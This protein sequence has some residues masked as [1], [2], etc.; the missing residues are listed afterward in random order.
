MKKR[1]IPSVLVA[2]VA[3][4]ALFAEGLSAPGYVAA[5]TPVFAAPE[6]GGRPIG[7]LLPA[8]PLIPLGPAE[9]GWQRVAVAGWTQSGAERALQAAPGLRVTRAALSKAGL[10][11]LDFGAPQTDPDTGLVW[12][13]TTLT[14]WVDAGAESVPDLQSLW[15]RAN[16][17]FSTRCTA[18]HVRRVPAR[19]T[20]NQWTSHLKVMGPRTGL[21]KDD[22]ALIRVF[23]QYHSADAT[24]LAAALEQ[25]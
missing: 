15:T 19:Y 13:R 14:G 16:T 4:T 2:C 10:E 24:A 8:A 18:C 25:D 22:Q 23:L 1:F 3:A 17:L 21:P 12:T 7:K 11:T 9:D 5:T 6:P 20:A